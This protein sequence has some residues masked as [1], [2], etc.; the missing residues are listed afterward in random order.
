MDG[1]FYECKEKQEYWLVGGGSSVCLMIYL[2][3]RRSW[4]VVGCG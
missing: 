4:G 1:C 3:V 2:L